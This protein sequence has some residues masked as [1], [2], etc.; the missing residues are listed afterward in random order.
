MKKELIKII[1]NAGKILKEGFYTDKNISF[2]A[3]KDLVTQFDVAVEK[4]LKK[5][6]SKKFK[7]FNIIAEESDN[8]NIEFNNS[9]II[10]PIDGTTNFVNGVPHTAISVGVYKNK[11][12]YLAVVYNPILDELYTA[13]I[14]KGA[15]LN[16]KKLKVSQENNF[17]KALLATGFPY[18]SGNDENDLNDV[19]KK[20]KDVLPL[21]QDLRRLGSASIDL[22]YV[23]RGTFD[24]YY[25][26]NLKPWDVSAGVLILTEAG[27]MVS[28]ISG[29]EYNLFE[30]KYLVATNGK[31]HN[32]LI[33]NLNL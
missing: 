12:P 23:A 22:C 24:G 1:K 5:K 2:K 28:N 18:S 9:I 16:G 32:E 6:F 30:D 17:Q 27:G 10:D 31:I 8:A 25:E 3:K 33:K 4:Y 29:N 11:K 14:G 20:I 21:C 13:K 26:M 15:Y 7:G 19:I